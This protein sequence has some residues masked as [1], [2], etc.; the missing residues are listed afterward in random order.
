MINWIRNLFKK[1]PPKRAEVVKVFYKFEMD[2]EAVS[3]L[4]SDKVGKYSRF[5]LYSPKE[6]DPNTGFLV[7]VF[8]QD[9]T[10]EEVS[11]KKLKG[12]LGK[13]IDEEKFEKALTLD[14]NDPTVA[15]IAGLRISMLQMEVMMK[16]LEGLAN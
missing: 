11:F 12:E 3:E 14:L 10:E 4:M 13:S 1:E 15:R 2:T 6:P 9:F 8:Y 5:E 7:A 16:I